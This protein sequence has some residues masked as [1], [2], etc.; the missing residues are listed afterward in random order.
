MG[1]ALLI[2]RGSAMV[3]ESGELLYE[4]P[5][6]VACVASTH[7]AMKQSDEADIPEASCD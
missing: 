6:A 7:I 2:K 5:V 3:A 4:I 1:A